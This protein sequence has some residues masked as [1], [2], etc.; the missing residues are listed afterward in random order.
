MPD[1]PL[2]TDE[3]REDLKR[4][5]TTISGQVTAADIARFAYA[6]DDGNP[7]YADEG[8]ARAAGFDGVIAPPLFLMV[9]TRTDRPL[10]DLQED[11][12]PPRTAPSEKLR[13]VVAGGT[14]YEF[15]QHM[16]PGDTITATRRIIDSYEKRGRSGPLVFVVSETAYRNQR[17]EK[18]AVMRFTSIHRP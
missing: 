13:R 5:A 4:E 1:E 6:V 11:G 7:L 2:L 15:F 14:E 18:V 9:P 8:Y 17:D 10:S 3:V 12:T 16:R